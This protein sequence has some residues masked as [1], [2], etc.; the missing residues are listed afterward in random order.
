MKNNQHAN[1][2]KAFIED[3]CERPHPSRGASWSEWA[4][5]GWCAPLAVGISLAIAGCGGSSSSSDPSGE[6]E[7]TGDTCT[8]QCADGV[9]N[10]SDGS[11]DCDDADCA[12]DSA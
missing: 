3:V 11:I 1:L 12:A 2:L 5:S 9:D 6:V 4:R 8:E 7:C 10:D